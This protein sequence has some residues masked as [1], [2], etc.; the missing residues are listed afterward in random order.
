M[1]FCDSSKFNE[2]MTKIKDLIDWYENKHFDKTSIRLFL[3]SGES[4]KYYVTK[5][6]IAHMLDN[7]IL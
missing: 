4:F 7:K 2:T 6:S 3:A 1:A 5:D